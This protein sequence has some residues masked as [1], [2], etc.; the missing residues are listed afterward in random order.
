MPQTTTNRGL[1]RSEAETA[2]GKPTA[3][4]RDRYAV[5]RRNTTEA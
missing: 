2:E 3:T 1:S 5:V 4:F